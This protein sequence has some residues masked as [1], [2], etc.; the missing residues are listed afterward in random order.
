MHPLLRVVQR[1]RVGAQVPTST[2]EHS[3]PPPILNP[4]WGARTFLTSYAPFTRF[5]IATNFYPAST[6]KPSFASHLA[7][8]VIRVHAQ[9][10]RVIPCAHANRLLS[11]TRTPILWSSTCMLDATSSVTEFHFLLKLNLHSHTKD[12][13]KKQIACDLPLEFPWDSHHWNPSR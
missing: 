3:L 10:C 1:V 2:H 6:V 7:N 11:S 12:N 13:F 5:N 4:R 9:R 8:S